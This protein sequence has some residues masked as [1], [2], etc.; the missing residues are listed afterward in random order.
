MGTNNVVSSDERAIA[1]AW[2]TA[3]ADLG[4]A[5]VAPFTLM[6]RDGAEHPFA[7]LV[8]AFGAPAGTLIC[9][10]ARAAD[11]RAVTEESGYHC[12]GLCADD[13]KEYHRELFVWLLDDFEWF[14]APSARPAWHTGPGGRAS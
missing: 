11:L 1:A 6:G 7:A 12:V 14:G 9:S 10:Q 3:A 2:R 4:I 8:C 5:V 13:Y